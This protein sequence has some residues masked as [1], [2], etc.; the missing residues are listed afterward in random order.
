[1]GQRSQIYIRIKDTYN[2]NPKLYAKYFSCNYGERMISRA[3]YG[4]EY[5]KRNEKKLDSDL[6]KERI[7]R[8]FDVN[9]DMKDIAITSD[10]IGE[11]I[12]QF[13]DDFKANSYIFNHGENNDGTLFIDVNENSEVKF[14]FTDSKLNILSPEEYMN[15]DDPTWQNSTYLSKENVEIC[16]NN[17]KFINENATLM[18]K[19]E[20]QEYINYDYSEQIKELAKQ[21]EVEVKDE[22]LRE[23]IVLKTIEQNQDEIDICE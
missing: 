4:I 7:N 10:L 5:I 3:R 2:E 18:T 12:E 14:C 8:I 21:L 13:A 19:D 1:M 6:V 23:K 22:Q 17:I 9:F 15:W 16:E 11:W 20:L